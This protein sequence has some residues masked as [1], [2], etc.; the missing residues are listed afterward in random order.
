VQESKETLLSNEINRDQLLLDGALSQRNKALDAIVE[1]SADLA[2][3]RGLLAAAKA[4]VAELEAE[5]A[6]LQPVEVP[7]VVAEPVA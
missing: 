3:A 4:R 2:I 5:V 1:L 6:K 7:V